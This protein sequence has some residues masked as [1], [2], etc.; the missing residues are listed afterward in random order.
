MIEEG[1]PIPVTADRF[2]FRSPAVSADAAGGPSRPLIL[3]YNPRAPFHTMPLGL[4]AVA[5]ALDRARFDVAIVDGRLEADPVVTLLRQME[6]RRTLL[7]GLGVLTGAPIGDALAVGR[8]IKAVH[9]RLPVVWGGWHPSLF[10]TECLAE[11]SVD[12]TVQGQGEA[13]L[14]DLVERFALGSPLDDCLGISFRRPDGAIQQNPPRPWLT[15][16][17]LPPVEYSLLDV[18]RY[19]GFKGRR[20]LDYVSSQGCFWR[21]GFCADPRVY[22]R[23]WSGQ[24]GAAL[25]ERLLALHDHYRFDDLNFQDETFFTRPKEVLVMAERLLAAGRPFS[26]AA[27]MRADQGDRLADEDFELLAAS[28]LRRVLVGVESGSQAM[29]DWMQKDIQLPQ[30]LVTA[31]KCRRA[32]IGVEFPF[33]VGFPGESAAAVTA[34]LNLAWTLRAMS[35]R[36]TTPIFFFRPYPGSA[37][38]QEME[39]QGH[40]LPSS[41]E[42]WARF[43]IYGGGSWVDE[44][45]LRRVERFRFYQRIGW[46]PPPGA[47]K[48]PLAALARWRCRS[49]RFGWPL[50]MLA[51]ERVRPRTALS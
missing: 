7:L 30:V 50:E 9:P 48:R 8:A 49:G 22:G 19:F 16:E 36:F 24:G 4:L 28:G 37:I 14:A 21:C 41:L 11:A 31:D 43:D 51:A 20:Q 1:R 32:G 45:T 2:S 6:G 46:D 40:R 35:P 34:S 5:S 23:Q 17:Q 15:Q 29:L 25:A 12:V 13:T 39:R 18:E 38:T 33:I 27:T 44:T 3:L 47:W 10:P 26:W 42:E